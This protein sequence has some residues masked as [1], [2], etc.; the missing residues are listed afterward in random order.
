M[1]IIRVSKC[2]YCPYSKGA[3]VRQTCFIAGKRI[4]DPDTMPEWC[5]L[6][7]E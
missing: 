3:D 1:K 5:P 6:E 7:E 2:G 4:C